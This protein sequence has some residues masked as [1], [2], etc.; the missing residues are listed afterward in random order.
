[1]KPMLLNDA[2]EIPLGDEW[3]Y[4]T[5]Y[6]GFRCILEWNE[7]GIKLLSRNEKQLN[8]LFPEIIR[9]CEKIHENV[10]AFLPICLDGEIVHLQSDVK[11]Q[12]SI[13]QSRGRMKK[14][15]VIQ[16]HEHAFPCQYVAFDLLS[17]KR[18]DL[19][20]ESFENRK[21]KLRELFKVLNQPMEVDYQNPIPLQLIKTYQ[22]S[23]KLWE[24]IVSN[25]G[26]G[27][28]A[29]RKSSQWISGKRTDQWIKVKNWR[30]INVI[31]TRYVKANGYFTGCVYK[32]TELNEVV[33]FR[34]GLS[35]EEFRT[36][37]TFFI[38][39]GK[40]S[41]SGIW[42]LKPSICVKVNC[43]DFN[44]KQLREPRFHSFNF[45]VEPEA[46]RWRTML[47]Q[48]NPIPDIIPVTHPDKP[49]WTDFGIEKDDYLLYLQTVAP[50]MLPFLHDRLLTVI[51]Y[52]HGTNGEKFYQKNVPDYA[53]DFVMTSHYEDI[54]Y[55]VCNDIR[56]LLWLGNQLALEFHIPFQTITVNNPTEIVFDLD[57]P[58]VDDFSLAVE[59]AFMM[60]V[61][62]DEFQLKSFVKTSGGKGL[63]IYIPL[64]VNTFS[65]EDTRLFTKFVCDFLCEQQPQWFTTERLKKN[66]D[67]KLYLDY[68]QHQAG[69]TIVAPFSPRGNEFA[70]VATPLQWEEVK[71]SLTP[72]IFTLPAVMER[73]QTSGNPFRDF[74]ET[75][76]QQQFKVVL[77]QLKVILK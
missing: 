31:A 71:H 63:Q 30:T 45:E 53:P 19:T 18:K 33:T 17:I 1:M 36:L 11:S 37:S 54:D 25:N 8:L 22:S 15:E 60:K 27:V 28:I 74:H 42:E 76:E 44:G 39:N 12:F 6:D 75:G 62:F 3:V 26:E 65:Y 64:P 48:L 7:N 23:E 35:D 77:E 50:Y 24:H 69:K 5:K 66:R 13:V 41:D 49:I 10:K 2:E 55:I 68:V 51:R 40:E 38:A 43:I 59:A 72:K 61:V 56:T 73:I 29:K 67:N 21:K 14:E 9:Y 57:P 70:T 52:P 16:A 34:H 20:G 47:R 4:E 32:G 46:V 58:S